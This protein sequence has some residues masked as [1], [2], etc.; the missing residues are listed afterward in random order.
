M[1]TKGKFRI[2]SIGEDEADDYT[3]TSTTTT[4]RAATTDCFPS[5]LSLS[6]TTSKDEDYSTEK[7]DISL[8]ILNICAQKGLFLLITSQLIFFFFFMFFIL[9]IV[10]F[11][12]CSFDGGTMPTQPQLTHRVKDTF[13]VSV[14]CPTP[15]PIEITQV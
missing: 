3:N 15:S 11:C 5:L 1:K 9:S 2:D 13:T 4:F 8:Q 7:K 6:T 10:G 12:R 14:Y